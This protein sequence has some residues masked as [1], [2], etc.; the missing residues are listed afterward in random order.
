MAAPAFRG[1]SHSSDASD[2][3]ASTDTGLFSVNPEVTNAFPEAEA[4]LCDAALGL[5]QAFVANAVNE[6]KG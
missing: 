5:A 4:Y 1:P 6:A 3:G 2:A